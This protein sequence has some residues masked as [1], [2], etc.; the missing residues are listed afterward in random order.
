MT[1]QNENK[2][3]PNMFDELEHV[4]AAAPT[5]TEAADEGDDTPEP[6]QRLGA[7]DFSDVPPSDVPKREPLNGKTVTITKVSVT[8][9]KTV[10]RITGQPVPP[11]ASQA[12]PTVK[13]YR[14]KLVLEFTEGENKFI[15]YY[16]NVKYFVQQQDGSV[17][18]VPRIPREGENCVAKIFR[19]YSDMVGKKPE[20]VSDK[21][22]LLGLEGLKA[23]I[24]TA[25]GTFAGR[26][27]MRNDIIK[28]TK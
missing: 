12:N 3:L 11:T 18:R 10:D 2:K 14:G 13:Y 23:T 20:E 8:A 21:Q 25:S 1:E 9:A 19:L 7:E 5:G 16:P 24:T 4:N 27:W 17:S 26:K 15:E 28:L 22:F 6:I